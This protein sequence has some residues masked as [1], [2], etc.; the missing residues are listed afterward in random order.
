MNITLTNQN[1]HS[2]YHQVTIHI[3]SGTCR[4]PNGEEMALT[5]LKK[6]KDFHHALLSEELFLPKEDIFHYEYDDIEGLVYAAIYV[7]AVLLQVEDPLACKF[8]INPSAR[9]KY[10]DV[11]PDIYFSL[12]GNKPAKERIPISQLESFVSRC[13]HLKFKFS[14]DILIDDTFTA[15]DLP[16]SINGDALFHTFDII[17]QWLKFPL[18][19]CS[20]Y[21]LRYISPDVGFG[22]F[23]RESIKK[24]DVISL[25]SG[26][27]TVHKPDSLEY[28]F[29]KKL[30]ILNLYLDALQHGNL[31]RFANHAPSASHHEKHLLTANLDAVTYYVNGIQF[32]LY[33]A[34]KEIKK[35]EQL[36]VNYGTNFFNDLPIKRFKKNGR[37][38]HK[39]MKQY[40]QKKLHHFNVMASVGIKEAQ[41]YLFLRTLLIVG[42]I[43]CV[44]MGLNYFF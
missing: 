14:E 6:N 22:V 5:D 18:K 23:S 38:A 16:H 3:P 44:V 28:A 32:V 15:K 33:T 29:E 8:K 21:E 36:L 7:Y 11:T 37:L 30:D 9:F 12:H 41:R 43:V 35:G 40:S 39:K 13:H 34:N 27:M 31:V 42:S 24:G 10:A 4:F 1:P 26:I 2:Q 20:C 17:I 19:D 25:Y